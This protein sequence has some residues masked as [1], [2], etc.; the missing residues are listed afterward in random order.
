MVAVTIYRGG[1]GIFQQ[2][3]EDKMERIGTFIPLITGF[4]LLAATLAAAIAVA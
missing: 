1:E 3:E 4:A 2:K